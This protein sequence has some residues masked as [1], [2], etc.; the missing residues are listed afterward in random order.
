[1][2]MDNDKFSSTSGKKCVLQLL[3]DYNYGINYTARV[4]GA[5]RSFS[6]IYHDFVHYTVICHYPAYHYPYPYSFAKVLKFK[7][8]YCT[9]DLAQQEIKQT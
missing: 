3:L 5:F 9:F 4:S 8:P 7:R 2:E 1:M 6:R